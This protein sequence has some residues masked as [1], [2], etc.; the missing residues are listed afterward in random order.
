MDCV[1]REVRVAGGAEAKEQSQLDVVL[2]CDAGS[3]VKHQQQHSGGR[4]A[5]TDFALLQRLALCSPKNIQVALDGPSCYEWRAA[6]RSGSDVREA[7]MCPAS[8]QCV[9]PVG[10][11]VQYGEARVANSHGYGTQ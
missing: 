10:R 7:V 3:T 9:L 6:V 11:W 5:A 2:A 4:S 8:K 1:R